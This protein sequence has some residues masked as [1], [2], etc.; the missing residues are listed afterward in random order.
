V[1]AIDDT[2]ETKFPPSAGVALAR[3]R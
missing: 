2:T 3:P 1:L